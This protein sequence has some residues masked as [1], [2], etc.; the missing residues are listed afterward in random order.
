MEAEEEI[1][2]NLH[3][4]FMLKA[5]WCRYSLQFKFEA[6]TSRQTISVKDTYFIRV[7]RTSN[8]DETVG[9]GECALFKGLSADDRPDYEAM[10]SKACENPGEALSSP[11]SSIRFGF[12][13]A[14][15][16]S[17]DSAWLRGEKG[18]TTNGLIWMGDRELMARRIAEK[19][20][21]GF[22]VLKLKIGGIDFDDELAL[23]A[24]V[25]ER[26]CKEDL[27]I[28][29]DANGSFTPENALERL[30]RLS[31]YDIH[32]L[33]QPIKAGNIE[34]MSRLC[35]QS[36]IAIA[37][38]EELIGLRTREESRSLLEQI[39]PQYIILKPS[40]CGGF[41]V[42]DIYIEEACRLGIGWWATS[43]L[44]SNI[45]LGAIASWVASKNPEIPQGL[46]TGALYYNNVES[47]MTMRGSELW[48]NPAQSYIMPE[49]LQW[50]Q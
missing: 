19:L 10:L 26:F 8:P 39:R 4:K 40:L 14:L 27:E 41:G 3:K 29:L 46:G 16:K 35:E 21:A 49:D 25:R 47:P 32:S 37:L 9:F 24:S 7:Y 23:L 5:Q 2:L 38:D 13:T 34:A 30:R 28:R 18:I 31:E 50:R 36:P 43:A 48:Y 12:E 17:A 6:R 42:S 45:G 11:Y 22:K 44:E 15:S 1:D 33:E 20:D